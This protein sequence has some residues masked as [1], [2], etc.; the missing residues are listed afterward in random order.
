MGNRALLAIACMIGILIENISEGSNS[1]MKTSSD[2]PVERA[3]HPPT[4]HLQG[5]VER[6]TYHAEDSGYTVARLKAPGVRDLVTIV[7]RFPDIHA[8]QSLRLTGYW[9]EHPKF[10]QQYQVIH[11]QETKPA[12][13]TGL[14]KYLGSGLIKGIGPVTFRCC[15]P[16]GLQASQQ[17]A[18]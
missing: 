5:I 18:S 17:D 6:V 16:Q 9:R 13:L 7:G 2:L 3:P 4:E 15:S 1:I 8:G 12:T 10:G 14:E 11:A